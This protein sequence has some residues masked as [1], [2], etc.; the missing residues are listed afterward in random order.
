MGLAIEDLRLFILIGGVGF[1]A[2][3][4]APGLAMMRQAARAA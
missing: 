2:F 1:F 3:M 4:L